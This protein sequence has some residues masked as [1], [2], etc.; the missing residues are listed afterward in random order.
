MVCNLTEILVEKLQDIWQYGW[1]TKAITS[2]DSTENEKIAYYLNKGITDQRLIG[3]KRYFHSHGLK[4]PI[5]LEVK[6]PDEFYQCLEQCE[7]TLL[8]GKDYISLYTGETK[9]EQYYVKNAKE[10]ME[11]VQEQ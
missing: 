8:T 7:P 6:N 9:Y 11:Y 3:H 4:Q 5:I 1:V 2:S 10:L